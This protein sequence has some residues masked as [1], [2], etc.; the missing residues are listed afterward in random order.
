MSNP[1]EEIRLDDYENHM[2]LNS[3]RQLQAMNAIM[4][5]QF[6][7]YPIETA[8]VLGVAGG[9]GL[10]HIRTDKYR[11]VYGVDVNEAYLSAVS[12]RY[13]DLSDVLTLLHLDLVQ[14]AERLPQAELLIANLLIEYIGYEAFRKAVLQ[15]AP[16][17]V[18]CV[19]Q[20]NT[21]EDGWVS[22]SP[23]L[24]AFD[25]LDAIHHQMEEKAL[26][27]VMVEIGYVE[28]LREAD[29]LPNGK[30]LVRVDFCNN[31]QFY[32]NFL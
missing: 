32:L 20:I 6:E 8:M 31:C 30:A 4:K 10:E 27:A 29:I 26:A 2:R 16:E 19:I 12:E 14:D 3:V 15:S 13:T 28:I 1:W 11:I 22:D 25:G 23:Y 17:Y 7:A 24:H 18:S 5:E 9:N 21:D